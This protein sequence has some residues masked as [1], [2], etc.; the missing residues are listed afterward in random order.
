MQV[1]EVDEKDCSMAETLT[2]KQVGVSVSTQG[3]LQTILLDG[4]RIFGYGDVFVPLGPC[5][6]NPDEAD[7]IKLLVKEGEYRGYSGFYKIL[8]TLPDE[9]TMRGLFNTH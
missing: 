7:W 2:G 8:N 3:L 6:D 9:E 1:H 4:R 5:R